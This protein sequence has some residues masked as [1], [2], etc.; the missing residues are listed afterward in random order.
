MKKNRAMRIAA[1]L[2]VLTMMTSCF[3]GGTFAKYVTSDDATDSARVA[4]WGV[5]ITATGDEAFAEKYND[6]ADENGT[7]VV[8]S[9]AGEDVLAPGTN[10]AL[11]GIKITG[12]PEVM[13]N[14][15]VTADLKLTGWN[16]P[17]DVDQDGTIE[18][19]ETVE[20]CPIVFTVNG[21]TYGTKD[22]NATNNY[23]TVALLVT[24]IQTELT[25][26]SAT[27][28]AANTNLATD[29]DVAISWSW[30]F[31]IDDS[32]DVKDTALGNLATAP[33]I[34]FECEAIVEQVN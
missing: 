28:V 27:N 14:I 20:Y 16:I 31:H 3:V 7:K 13:V 24:A 29:R 6:A 18:D 9:V 33:T 21:A 5:T 11:G 34:E 32:H 26:M 12:Q 15:T 10:G 17:Y 25:D 8:S 19:G 1:L 23:D 2:L 30:P 22:T 4:K